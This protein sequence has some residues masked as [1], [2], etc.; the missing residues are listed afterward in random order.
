MNSVPAFREL[1]VEQLR[2]ATDGFSLENIVSE[3]GEKAPNIVYKGCLEGD[4]WVAI[5]KFPKSAW[6]DPRQFAVNLSIR[7]FF[8]LYL[9]HN[10][11]R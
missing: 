8:S 4:R 5:K 11:Q 3:G 1:T 7:S 6:P 10:G 2:A 9:W